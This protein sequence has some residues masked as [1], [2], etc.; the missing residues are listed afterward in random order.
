MD[1]I[2]FLFTVASGILLLIM[3]AMPCMWVV[4]RLVLGKGP[5]H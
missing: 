2:P 5:P 4:I 3:A 1:L